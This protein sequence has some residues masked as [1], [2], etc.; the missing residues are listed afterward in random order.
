MGVQVLYLFIV[1]T[2]YIKHVL[3]KTILLNW[4]PTLSN[5]RSQ[6]TCLN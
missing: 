6:K 4:E 1:K 5:N 2:K 3:L